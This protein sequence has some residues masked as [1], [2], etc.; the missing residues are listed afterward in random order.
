MPDKSVFV[1][2]TMRSPFVLHLLPV[3]C[4]GVRHHRAP[5]AGAAAKTLDKG[6][7]KSTAETAG[8]IW[9]STDPLRGALSDLAK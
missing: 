9:V 1:M 6:A 3:A 4:Y 5:R 2:R 7:Q 8:L